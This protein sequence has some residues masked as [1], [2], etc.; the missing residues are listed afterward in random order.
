MSRKFHPNAA[1]K[2]NG[3]GE[4]AQL[5]SKKSKKEKSSEPNLHFGAQDLR[6][7]QGVMYIAENFQN[8]PTDVFCS[9]LVFGEDS[10]FDK[11]FS[12]GLQPWKPPTDREPNVYP[13]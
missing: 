8:F 12:N 2:I 13:P 3:A 9:P 1:L 6:N 7:Y 5:K 10:L 4:L 11:Y